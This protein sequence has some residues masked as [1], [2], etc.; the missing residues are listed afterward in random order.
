MSR[1]G[2]IPN[3]G[4]RPLHLYGVT[5]PRVCVA[6]FHQDDPEMVLGN[7]TFVCDTCQAVCISDQQAFTCHQC[8]SQI[9][10]ATARTIISICSS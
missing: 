5:D 8:G 10:L 2:E 9:E 4:N 6:A 1:V 7:Y 3:P